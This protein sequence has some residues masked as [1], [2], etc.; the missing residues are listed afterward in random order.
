[1]G[2]PYSIPNIY[3]SPQCGLANE[4]V[5]CSFGAAG[6]EHAK[7]VYD[8]AKIL[9]AMALADNVLVGIRSVADLQRLEIPSGEDEL[10]LIYAEDAENKV[11]LRKCS[12]AGGVTDKP[13]PKS[14][15]VKIHKSGLIDAGYPCGPSAHA[16]R[17]GAKF[18]HP[19]PPLSLSLC[20]LY[21]PPSA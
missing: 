17:R 10:P 14:A 7:L 12:K 8:D 13:M 11:I 2:L 19:S 3:E 15:F 1:M 4:C 16:I 6:L 9:F 5:L 21:P 20:H 18:L